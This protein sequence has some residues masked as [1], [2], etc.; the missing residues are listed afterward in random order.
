MK[1]RIAKTAHASGIFSDFHV[2]THVLKLIYCELAAGQ[3][4]E[5]NN[6]FKDRSGCEAAAKAK[7]VVFT[8]IVQ[9]DDINHLCTFTRDPRVLKC[10]S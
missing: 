5:K 10:L 1:E 4:C 8:I 7:A 9:K 6:I 2:A 3:S